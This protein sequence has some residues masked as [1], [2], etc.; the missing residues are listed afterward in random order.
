MA[1]LIEERRVPGD[2]EAIEVEVQGRSAADRVI[3]RLSRLGRSPC[4]GRHLHARGCKPL[5]VNPLFLDKL[6]TF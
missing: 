3:V 1:G 4:R 6:V 2:D 5:F